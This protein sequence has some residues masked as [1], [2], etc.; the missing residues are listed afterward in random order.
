M[1]TTG[2][3]SMPHPADAGRGSRGGP[4]AWSSE[5]EGTVLSSQEQQIW[6]DIE[7]FWAGKAEEP[8]LP[9]PCGGQAA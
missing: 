2:K 8:P 5:E 9:V 7:R 6:D 4:T 1:P 3:D